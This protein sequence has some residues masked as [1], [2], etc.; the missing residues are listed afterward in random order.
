MIKHIMAIALL[1]S[2][3]S[4]S[5]EN[6]SAREIRNL[7][8]S[9][10]LFSPDSGKNQYIHGPFL[11]HFNECGEIYEKERG[12]FDISNY[13]IEIVYSAEIIVY[14]FQSF[15]MIESI[16]ERGDREFFECAYYIFNEN[17][18]LTFDNDS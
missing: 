15:G 14:R 4:A 9:K 6:E 11:N 8:Q 17:L 5:D 3:N 18:I 12:E 10:S 1:T 16:Q 2:I 13:G 7:H